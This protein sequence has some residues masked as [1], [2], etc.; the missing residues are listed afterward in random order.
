MN[1]NKRFLGVIF[2]AAILLVSLVAC[3]PGKTTAE[4]PSPTQSPPTESPSPTPQPPTETPSPQPI[5]GVEIPLRIMPLGDSNV[6]GFCDTSVSCNW[7]DKIHSPE[8]G[9]GKEGCDW[10]LNYTNPEAKGFRGFL[11]DKL[12]AEGV[13]MVYVGSVNVVEGLA[14]EGH[15]GFTIFDTDYC[16]QNA[17]WL[18]KA[19]PDIILLHIGSNDANQNKTPDVIV[20]SLEKLLERIYEKVPETTEVIVAQVTPTRQGVHAWDDESLPLRNDILAEYNA[21]IPAVVEKIRAE[22]KHVSYV[23]M[24]NVFHSADEYD[25]A[26]FHPNPV[27]LER[28]AQVWFE[29]IMEILAQQP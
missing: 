19:K 12:I 29:K 15:S 21:G 9:Y 11:R 16:I 14:H 27:A 22:G 25:E 8:E 3:Q 7:P 6:E 28:M 5:L 10:A 4:T 26:G 1:T 18:E 17:D 13:E 24:W 20:K 23:N 2:L